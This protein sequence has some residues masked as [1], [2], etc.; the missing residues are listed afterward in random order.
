MIS[1]ILDTKVTKVNFVM[2]E[3]QE[4]I[5]LKELQGLKDGGKANHIHPDTQ[6]ELYV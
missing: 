5:E 2:N 3:L 6:K 1:T 4:F